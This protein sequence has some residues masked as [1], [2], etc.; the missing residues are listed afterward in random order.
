MQVALE[1]SEGKFDY[2]Q[3]SDAYRY[4]GHPAEGSLLDDE[5]IIGTFQSR[6]QDSPKQEA[7]MRGQLKIIGAHRRSKQILG[8]ADDCTNF[9]MLKVVNY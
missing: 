4:F 5:H 1:R 3:L 8:I 2:Q 7:E 9:E 6:A